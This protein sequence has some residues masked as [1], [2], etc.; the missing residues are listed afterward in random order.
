MES[1]FEK[2]KRLN[3]LYCYKDIKV[4][5][6]IFHYIIAGE[7]NLDVIVLLNGGMNSHEMWVDFIEHL[8]RKYKVYGLLNGKETLLVD[9]KENHLKFNR[10]QFTPGVYDSLRFDFEENHGGQVAIQE[11]RAE[12]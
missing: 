7:A 3:E 9:V 5:G 2:I 1:Y 11:I 10:H 8:S 6:A 4:D 12:A